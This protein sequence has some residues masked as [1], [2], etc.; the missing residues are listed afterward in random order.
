VGERLGITDQFQ[1]VDQITVSE[2]G[3]FE[4]L[5]RV[6]GGKHQ[7]SVCAAPPAV[8]GWATGS[9]P[10][11]RNSPQVGMANMRGIMPALQK[12]KSTKL[13]A[14]GLAYVSVSLPRQR[15]ETR[16]VKEMPE[17]EIAREIVQWIAE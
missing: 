17:D 6:E 4:V 11:P 9:L 1:G 15:R 2:D 3:S 12:A 5:E 14:N 8:L 10:E 7:V 13:D 16:V